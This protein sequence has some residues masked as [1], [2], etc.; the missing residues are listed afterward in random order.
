MGAPDKQ[1]AGFSFGLCGGPCGPAGALWRPGVRVYSRPLRAAL[2]GVSGRL[3]GLFLPIRERDVDALRRDGSGAVDVQ[4][5]VVRLLPEG[6]GEA[7]ALNL[8]DQG[9]QGVSVYLRWLSS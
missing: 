1:E 5:G 3:L 8:P 2:P 6:E 4:D 9:L 7:V